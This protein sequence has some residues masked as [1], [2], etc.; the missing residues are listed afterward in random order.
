MGFREV[1]AMDISAY[2][3]ADIIFDLNS[4]ELPDEFKNRFDYILDGG[5][6]EHVFDYPQAL[7]NIV[8][9][10]KVGGKIFHYVPATGWTNH[11]YYTL[12]PSLLADFYQSNGFRVEDLDILFNKKSPTSNKSL[13]NDLI[14]SPDYRVYNLRDPEDLD[15]YRGNLRCIAQK[16]RH[17]EIISNPKQ[18][19]WYG[20][21]QIDLLREVWAADSNVEDDNAA[22]GIVGV[23]DLAKLFVDVL[24]SHPAFSQQKIKAFF[25]DQTPQGKIFEGYPVA[26][27]SEILNWNLKTIFLATFDRRIYDAFRPLTAQNINVIT[28]EAYKVFSMT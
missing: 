18:V 1:H 15:G 17:Q 11:G 20:L 5:T 21:T 7:R 8:A 3:N 28:P 4:H 6:T 2:E 23:N 22:I 13:A 26:Q 12:S 10:L 14:S 9:M 19:Q 24:K 25:V 27:I 16:L